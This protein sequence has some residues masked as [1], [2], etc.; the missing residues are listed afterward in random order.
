M[1]ANSWF[2]FLSG[3]T[4]SQL[5]TFLGCSPRTRNKK[6]DNRNHRQ[7]AGANGQE[8]NADDKGRGKNGH[9]NRVADLDL[10]AVMLYAQGWPIVVA[11]TCTFFSMQMQ[12]ER[13]GETKAKASRRGKARSERQ[14][15]M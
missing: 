11:R 9:R 4:L 6:I 1:N 2:D 3:S 15:K 13:S 12:G 8:P 14:P 10:T 7:H 5:C